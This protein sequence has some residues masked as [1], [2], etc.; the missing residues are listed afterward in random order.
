MIFFHEG[1]PDLAAI[2]ELEGVSHR[3]ADQHRVGLFQQA[4]DDFDFFGNF[5]A[6]ENDHERLGWLVQFVAEELQLTLHQQT[7]RA[8]A[9]ALGH[10]TRHAFRARV[11]AMCRAERVVH[12]NIRDLRKLLRERR[13][14]RLFL[15]VVAHVFQQQNA[16]GGQRVRR[17]LD[18]F[19]DAVVHELHGLADHLG[20]FLRH[21]PQ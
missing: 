8:F 14:V 11:R 15:V 12:I 3:A 7:R 1:F 19:A 18:L 4:V 16:A 10:E 2:G 21:G 20:K 9:A 6:A 5:C 17:R 13:I